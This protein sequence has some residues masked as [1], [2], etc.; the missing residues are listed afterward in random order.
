[1]CVCACVCMCVCTPLY[2]HA[3]QNLIANMT[4]VHVKLTS[5]LLFS[6]TASKLHLQTSTYIRFTLFSWLVNNTRLYHTVLEFSVTPVANLTKCLTQSKG[7]TNFIFLLF[8][9]SNV[10]SLQWVKLCD[11]GLKSS[12][13]WKIICVRKLCY[14]YMIVKYTIRFIYTLCVYRWNLSHAL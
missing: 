3:R 9:P 6:H 5:C 14:I 1:M 10:Q 4:Q 7:I 13:L 2:V 8:E 11:K 12:Y